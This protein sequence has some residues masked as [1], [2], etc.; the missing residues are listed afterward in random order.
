MKRVNTSEARTIRRGAVLTLIGTLLAGGPINK[1]TV[2]AG[3]GKINAVETGS[4]HTGGTLNGIVCVTNGAVE[5]AAGIT[6]KSLSGIEVVSTGAGASA[7]VGVIDET[8]F[9]VAVDADRRIVL[10]IYPCRGRARAD[11]T[12]SCWVIGRG[13]LSKSQVSP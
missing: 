3:A 5:C 7:V 2:T 9:G 13:V 10:N 1:K 11:T 8:C 4:D 12:A 6:L